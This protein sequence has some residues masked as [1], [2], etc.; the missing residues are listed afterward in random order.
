MQSPYKQTAQLYSVR[1]QA[2]RP[3]RSQSLRTLTDHSAVVRSGYRESPTNA[4]LSRSDGKWKN[5]KLPV[6]NLEVF[7]Q[8]YATQKLTIIAIFTT[9]NNIYI[10]QQQWPKT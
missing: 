9:S 6:F 3:H 5:A 2:R 7:L 4:Y 10:K 8:S 1:R